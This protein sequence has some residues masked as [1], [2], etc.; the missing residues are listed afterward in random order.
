MKKF[1]RPIMALL[2]VGATTGA[3]ADAAELNGSRASMVRQNGIAK[4][5]GLAFVETPAELTQMVD[6]GELVPVEGNENYEVADFVSHR[7]ARPE[8]K[9]LIERLS[10]QYRE[11]TGQKLVVTSLTRPAA[12]QP[13]NAS[14]LSV[15]P[16]G[17]AMDLRVPT[18]EAREWLEQTLLSLESQGVLDV[19]RERSPPH[20][21][22]AVYPDAYVAH[23]D[24][25]EALEQA[26]AE[27]EAAEER[28]ALVRASTAEQ[29]GEG[30]AEGFALLLTLAAL[31]VLGV[32]R[33]RGRLA[34]V[35]N[36]IRRGW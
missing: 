30:D 33:L 29:A 17:M 36:R 1:I 22:V 16:A 24:R 8:V 34:T 9:L 27:R 4:D 31:A 32:P 5:K 35:G 26:R 6:R 25:L 13:W 21:H 2:V 3:A 14:S 7:A 10:A 18:G 19:T 11:A 12:Q 20:Y 28:S 23:V 15:H